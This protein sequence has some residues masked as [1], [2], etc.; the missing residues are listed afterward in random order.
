ME[1]VPLACRGSGWSEC[2]GGTS[3]LEYIIIHY[4]R[5][6]CSHSKQIRQILLYCGGRWMSD[7]D[8][9]RWLE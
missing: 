8:G 6:M 1:G 9:G 2:G 7:C 4:L 3:A 5:T